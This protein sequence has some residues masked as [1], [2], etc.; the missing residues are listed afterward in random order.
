MPATM[1]LNL[2]RCFLFQFLNFDVKLSLFLVVLIYLISFLMSIACSALVDPFIL[3]FL[4][5]P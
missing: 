5:V 4:V 1:A 2:L 3:L